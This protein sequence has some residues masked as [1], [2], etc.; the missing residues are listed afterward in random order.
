MGSPKSGA[1]EKVLADLRPQCE[2]VQLG[3][4]DYSQMKGSRRILTSPAP[5]GAAG[6]RRPP[7]PEKF[8]QDLMCHDAGER[9]RSP[10]MAARTRRF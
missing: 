8:S 2:E 3:H 6:S 9:L 7:P 5:A 4:A 10:A 1:R